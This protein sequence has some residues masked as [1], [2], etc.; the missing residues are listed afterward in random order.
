M[1]HVVKSFISAP[2]EEIRVA[3][4]GAGGTGS[5]VMQSL[6]KMNLAVKELVAGS[7]GIHVTCY[8]DDLIS[9]SNVVRQ[10]YSK[11]DINDPKAEI[12]TQ[13]INQFYNYDW[14]YIVGKFE[15]RHGN[16]NDDFHIVCVCVD[17]ME[18]RKKIYKNLENS[19]TY[20]DGTYCFDF[21]NGK[22]FGQIIMKVYD[23]QK[24][25]IDFPD[26]FWKTKDNNTEPS[27]SIAQ[28]LQKQSM[29]INPIIANYGCQLIFDLL[30]STTITKKGLF[31]NLD[32]YNVKELKI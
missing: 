29:F 14:D 30:T 1:E 32:N 19:N 20:S 31:I 10:L 6:A 18:S 8:D 24:T 21:G 13:R 17:S 11:S 4:I 27:C 5:Y 2:N 23:R 25:E 28:S 26:W 3:V 15:E 12:L 22:N 9:E 16:A 7:K